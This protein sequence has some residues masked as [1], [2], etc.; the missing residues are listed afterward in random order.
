MIDR[1][2]IVGHNSSRPEAERI[3][4]CDGTGGDIFQPETDLE[5]SHWRPNKTPAEYR[6]G[7]STEICFRFLDNQRLGSWTV[8]VNNHVDVDGIL[9]VYAL[10]HSQHALA[11]RQTF[12]EAAEIGDFWGWGEAPAQRMFQG[13]TGLMNSGEGRS[14]Y[15]D[16][17]R[18]I[19][20]LIDG[21]DPEDPQI[22]QSLMPLRRSVE[23]VEQGRIHRSLISN[24]LAHYIIPLAVAGD[25]DVRASFSPEFNEAIS[26]KAVLWP[27]V[28]ARWDAERA[29]L[30]SLERKTGWFHDLFFPGYLWADTEGLWRVPGLTYH[31]G[32]GTYDLAN[33]KLIAAFEMLQQQESAS[34]QWGLG[35]TDL[36]FGKELQ[37]RFPL[38][39]RYLNEHGQVVRIAARLSSAAIIA[40]PSIRPFSKMRSHSRACFSASGQCCCWMYRPVSKPSGNAS[41][42]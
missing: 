4:F 37:S 3:I 25:D 9:S 17:F 29:C 34:G 18:R 30:V 33:P 40:A 22:D 28:R 32:M 11:H 26:D 31:D 21:T 7:T 23:L 42:P 12:I 27:Q 39:G 20:A 6:A 13:L 8:A 35:G 10:I 16:A 38:V 41:S 2:E 5:L 1:F 19:P 15:E 36:P 24:R 14:V